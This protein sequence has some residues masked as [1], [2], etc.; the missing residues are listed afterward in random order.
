MLFVAYWQRPF[1]ETSVIALGFA[2]VLIAITGGVRNP[3]V[4]IGL[5]FGITYANSHRMS[6]FWYA[7]IIPTTVLFLTFCGY[8]FRESGK[9]PLS[10]DFISSK[11]GLLT[12]TSPA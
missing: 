1:S 9:Y 10:A 8:T 7:P 5:I 2:A 3:V 4:L 12:V 6:A 11:G